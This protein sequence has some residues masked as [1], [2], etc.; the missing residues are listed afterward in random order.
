VFGAV[1]Q[2]MNALIAAAA[3]LAVFAAGAGSP[4]HIADPLAATLPAP[5]K[6]ASPQNIVL[7]GATGFV[8]SRLLKEAIYRGHT[9]TA[10]VRNPRKLP[11]HARLTSQQADVLK[12]DL[13]A[14]FAGHD[15]VISAYNPSLPNGDRGVRAIIDAVKAA[16]VPR[17]LVV[18]GAGSLE[19]APGRLLVDSPEFPAKW[20]PGALAT[21]AFLDAL[22]AERDLQWTFLSP[23]AELAP[24]KRTGRFRL[25]GDQLL[26]DAKGQSRISLEDYAVAM[27][28]ELERP[29]HTGRR[30]TVA[31]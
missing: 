25:G 26:R 7:I 28:D 23:A 2:L 29:A 30:F 24:G 20:K 31:Y 21:A 16:K 9:V 19:I 17:L 11:K 5:V 8:G 14:I 3:V 27:L 1:L 12:D 18:G 4:A 6:A 22:R 13:A 10:V 15:A